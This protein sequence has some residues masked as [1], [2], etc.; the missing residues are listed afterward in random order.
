VILE[1]IVAVIFFLETLCLLYLSGTVIARRCY[2]T[3]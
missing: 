3:A 1:A 2:N